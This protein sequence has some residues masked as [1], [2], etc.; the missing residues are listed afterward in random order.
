[1]RANCKVKLGGNSE[2]GLGE[3]ADVM[4]QAG[5]LRAKFKALFG[6]MPKVYRAPGRVN[7]IG[8]HTD[9]ND[10]FVMPAAIGFSCWVAIAAR[11]DYNLVIHSESFADSL[12]VNLRD[13]MPAPSGKWHD[14][15]LGV[16]WVLQQAGHNLRGANLLIHGEV[17]L[18]AGLSSSA[19]LEVSTGL[20]LLDNSGYQ[21]D[22]TRLA[23]FCQR[24]EN[25]FV[26]A[27]CG[28]MDQFISCHGQAG[29]G[30]MLDCRSLDYQLIPIPN[31]VNLVIC[32]T[33][34]R[35]EH[36]SGEYNVR[37]A[38][39]EEGVRVLAEVLPG[40]RALRD[41]TLAQLEQNRGRLSKVV[42]KRCRHVITENDRVRTAA[43][44]LQN[45][46]VQS[47]SK[48]MADSHQSLRDDYEVSC[49]EL[50]LMVSLASQQKGVYGARMTGGG[51]GGCTIN[52]VRAEN[53]AEFQRGVAKGY[54]S[55]TGKQPDIHVC[56]ASQ[57]AEMLATPGEKSAVESA[58]KIS[59][60]V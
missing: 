25:E 1:M 49:A 38:E 9:Y 35:H 14:Y 50:D 30:L 39:C 20:A 54:Y 11:D 7:L 42:Y 17:P 16:A 41:V 52:L 47:L 58:T 12:E 26:G 4:K 27:R 32:N 3:K 48:L 8:E 43:L 31:G 46:A 55:A 6:T 22:R 44:A 33:M 57:G 53:T 28:I 45:G 59:A 23:L 19:A 56:E 15:P 34:V 24:A 29:H 60:D 13:P 21:V 40:V 5:D 2:L 10:G 36:G 37:R 18:G 51:F